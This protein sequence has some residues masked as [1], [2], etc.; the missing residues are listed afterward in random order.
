MLYPNLL[1][2]HLALAF[3]RRHRPLQLLEHNPGRMALIWFQ[4]QFSM[5][6]IFEYIQIILLLHLKLKDLHIRLDYRFLGLLYRRRR[7]LLRLL[8]SSTT[9]TLVSNFMIIILLIVTTVV[10]LNDYCLLKLWLR[11]RLHLIQF[12]RYHWHRPP[13]HMVN[14]LIFLLGFLW[15]YPFIHYRLFWNQLSSFLEDHLRLP[16]RL[17]HYHWN[18]YHQGQELHLLILQNA[19]SIVDHFHYFPYSF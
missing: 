19:L 7:L 17:L 8:Y 9:S 18:H 2:L 16:H 6:C 15:L 11:H 5:V 3:S 12:L 4:D 13:S 1:Y 14:L 10:K